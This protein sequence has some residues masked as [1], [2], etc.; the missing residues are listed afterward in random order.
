MKGNLPAHSGEHV[1]MDCMKLFGTFIAVFF[2]PGYASDLI[3]KKLR[4]KVYNFSRA[5]VT[6]KVLTPKF[7]ST[8]FDSPQEL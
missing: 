3:G 7:T 8:S 6:L 1:E 4:K 5:A 2:H